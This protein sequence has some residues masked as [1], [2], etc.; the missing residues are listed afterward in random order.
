MPE[1]FFR[2]KVFSALNDYNIQD[3]A[4][5]RGKKFGTDAAPSGRTVLGSS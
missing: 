3:I 5:I 2:Y 4:I 1:S